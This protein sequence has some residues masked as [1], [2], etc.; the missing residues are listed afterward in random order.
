VA[1][2][3]PEGIIV[4]LPSD[5]VIRD[6]GRF[7]EAVAVAAKAAQEGHVVTFGMAPTAPETGYGYVHRG[8]SLEAID[9]AFQ[10]QRFVEKPDV[11]TATGYLA[12]G[13]YFWNSG[14]FV[15]RADVLIAE[16]GRHAPEVL[17]A[18]R[19]AL[20]N[21]ARDADFVRLDAEAFAKAPNISIDYALMEKTDRAAIV[22]CSIGWNDVGAWSALWEIR[23]Q[24][25]D[26]NVLLG[27]VIAHDSTGSYVHSHRRLTALVGVRDL[28]VV[29]TEDALLVADR[30]RSQD[31]K[32]IV[33]RLKSGKRSEL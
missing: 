29:D 22:P 12:D 1:E 31:V 10:V 5:H 7:A 23:D 2:Q 18:A 19:D 16:L 6:T 25:A 20:A 15:F 3:D 27:D 9:G 8:V 32:A 33:D 24:D 14:M 28:I 11:E 21:A 30:S 17:A 13:G 4:L 26:N